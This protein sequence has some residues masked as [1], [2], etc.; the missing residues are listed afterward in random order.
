VTVQV[1]AEGFT[2]ADE[3]AQVP[4]GGAAQVDFTL[5][6]KTV[7]VR[8]TL[9][10]LIRTKSGEAVKATVRVVELK[11]KLQV[12]A[13][14]RFSA[15]VPSGRY[16]LVIEARGFVTQT[17]SVEVSGGDQAIFHAELERLR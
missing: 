6:P 5:T 10:G 14:G 13:D 4:P 3:V 11:L 1:R 16:T 15:E 8:A 7:A 17:K 9:R 12:K 2:G